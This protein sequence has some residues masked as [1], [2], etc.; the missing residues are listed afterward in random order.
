V[1]DLN[2]RF[3][4]R[5]YRV[6]SGCGEFVR[7]VYHGDMSGSEDHIAISLVVPCH[8]EAVLV[9]GSLTDEIAAG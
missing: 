9:R 1:A 7:Q 8:N 3:A 6:V 5:V 4:L 2:E